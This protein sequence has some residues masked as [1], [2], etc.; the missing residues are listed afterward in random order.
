MS[1][2]CCSFPLMLLVRFFLLGMFGC[3]NWAARRCSFL[4]MLRVRFFMLAIIGCRNRVARRCSS[5]QILCSLP[6]MLKC[7]NRA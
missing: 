6:A 5:L 7:L 3:R 1:A 4:L 2:G